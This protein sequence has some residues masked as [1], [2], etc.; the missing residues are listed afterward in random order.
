MTPA[1]TGVTDAVWETIA[2]EAA[3]E[4]PLWAAALRPP[5]SRERVPVFSALA[6]D[7]FGL[8]LETI[9]EG[10]LLHYGRPRLFVPADA[11]TAVLLGDYLF[12]HGLVRLAVSG[13]VPAVSDLAELISVSTQLRAE[14]ADPALDGLAWAATAVCLGRDAARLEQA[15]SALRLDRDPRGLRALALEGV[16][17]E[18][19]TR[20]LRTH[21]DRV[22]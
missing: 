4:S 12:A 11:D 9:Y 17:D 14:Q 6:E 2:T 1:S 22:Q 5:G 21:G 16:G 20:A 13:G 18:A 7:R 3:A 10:Y 19:L 8:A 15:R